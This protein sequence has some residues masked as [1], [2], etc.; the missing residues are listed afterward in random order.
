[1]VPKISR[2]KAFNLNRI[3]SLSTPG[4]PRLDWRHCAASAVSSRLDGFPGN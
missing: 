3:Y 1:M 2:V 4:H